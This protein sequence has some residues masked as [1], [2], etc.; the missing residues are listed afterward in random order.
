MVTVCT[1]WRA[2]HRE[3]CC[4]FWEE[5]PGQGLGAAKA[6]DDVDGAAWP[7]RLC[8]CCCFLAVALFLSCADGVDTPAK[9]KME[10]IRAERGYAHAD[11][12]ACSA[13]A[14]GDAFPAK[15][16]MFF[17]EHLHEDEE[18]RYVKS[19]RRPCPTLLVRDPG[20]GLA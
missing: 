1:F 7:F 3:G 15:C 9:R 20:G 4:F 2:A 5:A 12:V 14:M 8:G 10:A 17:E 16:A 11:E 19:P 18:I 6:A 13:A